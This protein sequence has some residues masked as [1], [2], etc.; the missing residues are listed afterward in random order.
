MESKGQAQ[1]VGLF[2]ATI[3]FIICGYMYFIVIAPITDN[4]LYPLLDNTTGIAPAN[5]NAIKLMFQ[6][7]PLVLAITGL[8]YIVNYMNRPQEPQY[9]NY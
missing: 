6:L 1:I 9:P 3:M 8:V 2:S 7:I 5:G 4:L